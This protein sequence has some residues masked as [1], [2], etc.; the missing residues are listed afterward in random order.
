MEKPVFIFGC[1]N[2]GT[3]ILWESLLK[4]PKFS[5]PEVE[6][7]DLVELPDKMKHY[8]GNDT[9]RLWA[10]PKFGLSYYFTE[11]DYE[12]FEAEKVKAVYSKYLDPGKRF[13]TKSPADT[14]RA[15]L[16]QSYF[17]DAFFIAIVRNGYAVTEG[18]VR[19]RKFD[20]DRPQYAGLQTTIEDAAEQWF[21]AN[22]VITSHQKFLRKYLIIKYED[23]V[24]ITEQTIDIVLD[25]LQ[26]SKG[27]FEVP[28]FEKDRNEKQIERLSI[29]D[30]AT[31]SRIAGPM[32]L[33][34]EYQIDKNLALDNI[35]PSFEKQL[36]S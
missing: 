15:R 17:P 11:N 29:N 1:C 8:L 10:H 14:L 21:R 25:F 34:Y 16:I 9:F 5:G 30:I 32:L 18:I 2:S 12:P 36:I 33:H 23:L 31:I 6:G 35:N 24:N 20:P 4:H 7:Q 13:I 26:V 27:D 22:I 19:K 28:V 3:T